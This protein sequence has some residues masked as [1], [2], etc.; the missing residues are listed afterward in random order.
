M[1][2]ALGSENLVLV[3]NAGCEDVPVTSIDK[4]LFDHL[5]SAL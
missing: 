3:T 4:N 1:H 5:Y 2:V